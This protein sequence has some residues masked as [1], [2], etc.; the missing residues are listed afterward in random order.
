MV[1]LLLV[2]A[3]GLALVAL[4]DVF[5]FRSARAAAG[6]VSV[7]DS[8]GLH[9]PPAAHDS[10]P[11]ARRPRLSAST[12]LF[13]ACT[14]LYLAF[15][16]Y[17]VLHRNSVVGDAAARVAQAWYVVGSRDPHLAAIGFV[18]NPLPSA[19]EIP[20]VMLRGFWPAL[21]EKTFAGCIVSALAMAGA[22][23]QLRAL[24]RDIGASRWLTVA[25]VACFA[26]NPMV[27]YYGSNGMSEA[28]YL[29]FLIGTVRYLITWTVTGR[30]RPLVLTGINLALAFLTR[31]EALAAA[32]GVI[33]VVLFVGMVARDK[34]RSWRERLWS[35]SADAVIVGVPVVTS[36]VA[37]TV[38]SWVITGEPFQQFTSRYGNASIIRSAGGAGGTNGTGWPKVVLGLVQA[39]SYAPIAVPLLVAAIVIAILRRDRRFLALA[40]LA[41]P[42]AFSLASYVSGSTFGFMRYYIPVLPLAFITLALLL[43][44]VTGMRPA[45][46]SWLRPSAPVA[47]AIALVLGVTGIATTAWAMGSTRIAPD[48]HD[49]L[50]PLFRPAASPSEV[51]VQSELESGRSIARRID[52]LGL[53]EGSVAIDTFDCGPI[54]ALGSRHQHQ[55]V[56]TSDRD[57]E[58]IVADPLAFD[59]PY[60][61]VP[62]GDNGIEAI[63][64]AHP[65][66][67]EGGRVGS[68]QTEVV[69]EYKTAGCPTY[70]LIRIVSDGS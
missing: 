61:L 36:F 26:L 39:I 56:I 49:R 19:L 32:V 46:P 14:L 43:C 47:I 6:D 1:P 35:A 67:F 48:E 63:G 9:T 11:P 55:F 21:T 66:I 25:I 38:V 69:G 4:G 7:A 42:L 15:A 29:L 53:N 65:G 22:V 20:L 17:I 40:A 27:I 37:W 3:A 12:V 30:M 34:S 31:Y 68:L 62:A 23:L 60:L 13:T 57:F 64:L 28:L 10:E 5:E 24:L 18:W 51:I 8:L 41:G 70:R 16:A 33:A 52:R 2:L 45:A 58:R 44:P 54:I 59:V 50:A